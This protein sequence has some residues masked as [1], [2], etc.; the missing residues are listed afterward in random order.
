MATLYDGLIADAVKA[1]SSAQTVLDGDYAQLVHTHPLTDIGAAV[2]YTA[3]SP[4]AIPAGVNVIELNHGTVA[5]EK[6]IA[7]LVD[8]KGLMVIKNT[9]AT[10]TA[11]HKITVTT[12]TFNGTHKVATLDAPGGALVVWID[13]AGSGTVIVNVGEVSLS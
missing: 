4:A 3:T 9:S 7:S 6:T 1:G 2:E 13:S 11:A 8:H 10:G 5:I 12:G